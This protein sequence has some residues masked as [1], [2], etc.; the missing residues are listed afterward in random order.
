M[1]AAAGIKK[2][3]ELR[4]VLAAQHVRSFAALESLKGDRAMRHLICVVALILGTC[5]FSMSIV[6]QENSGGA[7]V[8]GGNA[9]EFVNAC[10][11][12]DRMDSQAKTVPLKDAQGLSYCFGY[13][14]GLVDMRN[15]LNA[16]MPS[17]R[18]GSY[19]APNNASSTQL[20]KI[21]TRYGDAHPEELN[22]PAI[23][24]VTNALVQ[25]FP[26]R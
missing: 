5:A 19:C 16:V 21:V 11:A 26:C 15:T 17:A 12:V 2:D 18:T 25:S 4:A 3:R 7:Y 6:G 20:A 8:H 24:V 23:I 1:I 10:A 9:E 13:I 22:L 14:L